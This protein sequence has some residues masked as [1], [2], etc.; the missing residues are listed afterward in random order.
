MSRDEVIVRKL[1][2]V[3][4]DF[5]DFICKRDCRYCAFHTLQAEIVE[6]TKFD[7]CDLLSAMRDATSHIELE[8]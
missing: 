8:G 1:A 6:G 4:R 5:E 3:C 2:R 7:F